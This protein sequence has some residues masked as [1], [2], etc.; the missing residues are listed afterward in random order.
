METNGELKPTLEMLMREDDA[1]FIVPHNRPDFDAIGASIAMALIVG[2]KY[3][4]K[5]YIV[6]NDDYLK[7]PMDIRKV[8]DDISTRYHVIKV[9]D[10]NAL[11][12][13]KSLMIMVDVN[14]DYLVSTKDCLDNFKDILIID[15]HLADEH[16]IQTPYLFID[17]N[18]SSTCEEVSKLLFS[19]NTKISPNDA[20][21]LLAGIMLDTNKLTKNISSKTLMVLSKLTERGASVSAVNNLFLED[22]EHDRII[23]K[24]VDNTNFLRYSIAIAA[25]A[26]NSERIYT[27]ED[28]AKCADYNLK[29]DVGA[30]FA[31]AYIDQDMVSVSGRSK[32]AFD[33]SK[34]MVKLGGGGQPTSGAAR[35]KGHKI[36]EVK[37]YLYL[38]LQPY[39]VDFPTFEEYCQNINEESELRLKL[40]S[41]NK[42]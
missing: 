29:F 35:I 17:T 39:N 37:N 38:L 1:V 21:Y 25:D 3:K 26:S 19:L 15:H 28:I 30:S 7:L 12:T 20:N 9:E 6:I 32:E 11:Q 33:I 8:I 34:V 42:L 4:K 16:T 40:S 23:H 2:K 31:I 36:D 22:Y 14:K 13:D 5:N 24:M 27:I 41:K 18:T 10:I